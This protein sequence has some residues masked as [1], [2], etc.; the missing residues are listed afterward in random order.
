MSGNL[1]FPRKRRSQKRISRQRDL[2]NR[3]IQALNKRTAVQT[4]KWNRN[5]D[6][7]SVNELSQLYINEN[8]SMKEIASTLNCSLHKIAYWMKRYKIDSRSRSEATYVKR[9]PSGDPFKFS[10]PKTLDKAI[11]FGMGL[12]LY[13]GEGTKADKNSLRLG[14]SDSVL[15][16]VFIDF[17]FT[18]FKIDRNKLRFGIQIFNDI[19]PIDA[20]NFWSKNLKM[21][22]SQFFKV[23]ITPSRGKGIYK[24]KIK[25][26]VLTIYLSNK[27]LRDVVVSKLKEFGYNGE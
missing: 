13:W 15:L 7:I 20:L 19:K 2:S 9:N 5:I 14:N 21:N 17:L 26:G 27:K 11:L 4:N 22:K 8:K 3:K 23:I 1:F 6:S 16:K 10:M 25:Y 12:G 18:F 24:K